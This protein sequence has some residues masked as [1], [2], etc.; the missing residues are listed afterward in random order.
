MR[1][2]ER[3]SISEDTMRPTWAWLVPPLTALAIAACGGAGAGGAASPGAPPPGPL[4]V[5]DKD[6][7]PGY[8]I[9]DA[10]DN[11]NQLSLDKGRNGYWYTFVDKLGSSITPPIQSTFII[12]PGGAG[13]S[14]HAARMM[15]KIASA[16]QPLFA[17][18]GFSFLDPKAP[19]DATAYTGVA[20]YAKSGP[21]AVASVRLKVPDSDTD[22][23]G[24]TCTEC[25]N[26]FGADLTLTDQWKKYTVPFAT[27][28][29]M[30]GWGAPRPPSINKAKV[31][32]VQWQVSTPGA[33]YDVWVDNVQFTGCP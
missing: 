6:C 12:S 28:K 24:K 21:G 10:E 17:G 33:S 31:L 30:E 18:M 2:L 23:E 20:F 19:Y 11:N 14:A 3:G 22:P 8:L 32:G 13:G 29:Q 4:T 16:G 26:D 5:S 25:F 27:M 7:G 15:G 9:D 1:D